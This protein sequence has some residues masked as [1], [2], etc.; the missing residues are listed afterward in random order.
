MTESSIFEPTGRAV[1]YVD[2]GEGPVT[3]VL[4][5]G[6][7]LDADVLGVI[8]HYLAEEAGFRVVRIDSGSQGE[9]TLEERV[10]DTLAVIDHLG[11]E[12][13]WIGGHGLGG[14]VARTFANAHTDRVN[15]LLLLGVEDVDIPLPP[16]MPVL[17]I[18]G[19]D[20]EVTV[21]AT[22]DKLQATAP[23]RASLKTLEG[24]DHLF[25]ATHP[26]DA[27]VIIEE[28]LDWD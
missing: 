1:A 10:A 25:P 17:I 8:S 2:E 19:S 27:A 26:V 9:E 5:P 11:I 14:T 12:D 13:T 22:G 18:Q 6:R 23:E 21:P 24:A 16:V 20:D 4:I 3:L 15:G 7:G 28:Y